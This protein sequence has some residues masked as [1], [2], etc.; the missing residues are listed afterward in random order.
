MYNKFILIVLFLLINYSI[1]AQ[2]MDTTSKKTV[3]LTPKTDTTVR[4]LRPSPIYVDGSLGLNLLNLHGMADASLGYRINEN[5]G[6]GVTVITMTDYDANAKGGGLQLRWTPERHA[7]MKLDIG[8]VRGASSIDRSGPEVYTYVKKASDAYF[9]I[10]VFFRFGQ[11]L[12][13]GVCYAATSPVTFDISKL[14]SGTIPVPTN[15]SWSYSLGVF[16]PQ[17]GIAI[18]DMPKKKKMPKIF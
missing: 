13:L 9:R 18:P 12:T 10:G 4:K 5:L 14:V 11:V 3:V 17:I 15:R 2:N 1:K 16:T 8:A 6:V 7:L